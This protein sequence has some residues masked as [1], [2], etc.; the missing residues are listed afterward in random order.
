MIMGSKNKYKNEGLPK[1]RLGE[2]I[3][4]AV[5][6]VVFIVQSLTLLYP[7]FWTLQNSLKTPFE[8]W[9]STFKMPEAFLISNYGKAFTEV[10]VRGATFPT[11]AFNTVWMA[12]LNTFV[13]IGCSAI[14]AY[15][16]AKYKFPGKPVIYSIAILIQVLP[17]IG[18][19]PAAFQFMYRSGIANNPGLIWLAWASG[20]DFSFIVLY[21]YFKSISWSYAEAAIIDGASN[22]KVMYKI[23]FPQAVPAIASLMILNFIGAWN[24]YATPMFYMKGYPNLALAIFLF[25]K[26]SQFAA[27]GTPVFLSSIIISMLPILLIFVFFQ[28]MIMTNVTAGG[29]K[30]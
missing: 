15:P 16:M 27:T 12:V 8:Y 2:T 21:G 22:F 24:N 3:F 29:L 25:D 14:A 5:F 13:S 23:M 11:L 10:V 4:L 7:I 30:G 20:F 1:R 19:G 18:T 26:E 9:N 28:R 17:V 6:F